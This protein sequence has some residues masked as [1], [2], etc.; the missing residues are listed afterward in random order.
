VVPEEFPSLA[1]PEEISQ[2][3]SGEPA[4]V[5]TEARGI[6]RCYAGR[7]L[8]HLVRPTGLECRVEIRDKAAR[9]LEIEFAEPLQHAQI[10]VLGHREGA[11]PSIL[12]ARQRANRVD[13]TW[14]EPD[15]S[16]IEVRVRRHIH[17]APMIQR[18]RTG[19]STIV[20][21][22]LW[23][24]SFR[25]T[26]SGGATFA[27]RTLYYLQPAGRTIQLCEAH[28]RVLSVERSQIQGT[29]SA[30][31]LRGTLSTVRHSVLRALER[32]AMRMR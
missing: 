1:A 11:E 8:P 2:F 14:S 15:L 4:I 9:Y 17:A 19:Q 7:E 16:W 5:L 30:V 25:A 21:R 22:A 31:T 13:V 3:R 28:T 6:Y 32:I 18:I 20:D 12:E 10:E 24:S 27:P 23:A 26:S 29:P